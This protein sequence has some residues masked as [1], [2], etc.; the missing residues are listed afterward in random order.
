[1]FVILKVRKL[2]V[3]YLNIERACALAVLEVGN[4][5]FA[6]GGMP[7]WQAK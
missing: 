4:A 5:L 6:R 7:W 2:C 3:S 1:M